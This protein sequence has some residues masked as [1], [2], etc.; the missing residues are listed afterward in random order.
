MGGGVILFGQGPSGIS[1]CS[2]FGGTGSLLYG[3]TRAFGGGAAYYSNYPGFYN[4]G[5]NVGMPG[6]CR[7]V[8]G[9]GCS[10]PN[11]A[12]PNCYTG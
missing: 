8:W 2:T 5:G 1:C 11:A 6:A 9:A 4:G 3:Q 12:G 10:Y 7:I